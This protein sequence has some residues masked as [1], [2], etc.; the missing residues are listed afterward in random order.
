MSVDI[1]GSATDPKGL[2]LT[3]SVDTSPANGIVSV[4]NDIFNYTPNTDYLGSDSFTYK[5]TN[6]TQESLPASVTIVVSE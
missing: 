2:P 5:V 4:N 6:G 1:S 3:Y